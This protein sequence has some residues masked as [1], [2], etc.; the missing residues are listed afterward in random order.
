M[1][2]ATT[3]VAE[4]ILKTQTKVTLKCLAAR[5]V[6]SHVIPYKDKIPFF[7]RQFVEMH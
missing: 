7:L 3:G 2:L 1:Q 5:A 6:R 4:I